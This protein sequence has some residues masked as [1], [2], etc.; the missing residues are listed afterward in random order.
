MRKSSTK[1]EAKLKKYR[2]KRDFKVTREPAGARKSSKGRLFV[3]QK[4]HARRLHWDLR[5]ETGGVLASWAV[6]KEPPKSQ[7][8]KRLAVHVEDHP[9]D[10]ASFE[11]QIPEGQYGAGKVE[12]WDKGW[13]DADEDIA[14]QIKEGKV[15]FKLN[16]E[17]L[18]GRY[19]LVRMDGDEKDKE[20][21]LF[22]RKEDYASD[23]AEAKSSEPGELKGAKRSKTPATLKPML[24]VSKMGPPE[25]AQWL[26]EIKWD[27]YR[28]LAFSR[29]GK[30]TFKT[31]NNNILKLPEIERVLEKE[32]LPEGV[33]DGEL[34]AVDER[35]IS[36]FRIAHS[37]IAAKR[38]SDLIVYFFD[39]PFYNGWDLRDCEL[40]DRKSILE[41]I[42]EQMGSEK[43]R[44][45]AHSEGNGQKLF[46]DACATGLEGLISKK[47]GS[48][49][50]SV[51][52]PNWVK[53]RCERQLEGWIGG[54]TPISSG[55]DEIGALLIGIKDDEGRLLYVGK[56]G[57]GFTQEMRER[58]FRELSAQKLE[59]APFEPSTDLPKKGVLW[60]EPVVPAVV[61]YLEWA[62]GGVMRQPKLTSV[63]SGKVTKPRRTPTPL[64][65]GAGGGGITSL[66]IKISSADR[67]IDPASGSTKG[68]VA[69][70][71]HAVSKLILPHVE[72]RPLP[73]LRCP[74]GIEGA[75][76]F[77]KHWIK[78]L[79]ENVAKVDVEEDDGGKEDYMAISDERGLLALAQMGVVELHP[80]GSR[81]RHLEQPDILIFDLDPGEGI[82]WP[83]V[84]EAA[85]QV[86]EALESIGLK[87]FAKLSGGKGVH[88]VVPIKPELEWDQAKAFCEAFAREM[89]KRFPSRFTAALPKTQRKGKIFLDYLRNG[90]G[91]TAVTAYSLRARANLPVAMP[92]EWDEVHEKF[93]PNAFSLKAA[94]KHIEKRNHDPWKDFYK[95][96]GS[97]KKALRMK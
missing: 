45:S 93:L 87:S 73:V 39:L 3:I 56:V 72:N 58:L 71:Y 81:M 13:Y 67:V 85:H 77:H 47:K 25:G 18:K 41:Q 8:V 15:E 95:R 61:Q 48:H 2:A 86:R 12:I 28:V 63:G 35:G 21:W 42:V 89:A 52:S 83:D 46:E 91:A 9:L 79:P 97:L 37:D 36:N 57:T 69:L 82:E 60:T 68:D 76:F 43:I 4:H 26:R 74:E 30:V 51:R 90:R 53:T 32:Y 14:K 19:I 10:Y 55:N 75:C 17:R 29:D 49:Y 78:G 44:Y 62:E 84:A 31:R 66:S 70:Y 23:K 24:C 92:V 16:G 54:F 5:L 1:P 88:A 33:Y 80:W 6:P 11:G 65:S 7:G 22:F 20:N 38:T 50:A 96:P 64:P 59:R 40:E 94:I 34:V 27:G